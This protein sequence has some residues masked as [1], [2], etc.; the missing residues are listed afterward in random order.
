MSQTMDKASLD[1]E[2]LQRVLGVFERNYR[3]SSADF[4]RAHMRNEPPAAD[5]SRWHRE[6]WSG[7]YRQWLRRQGSDPEPW[8]PAV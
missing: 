2:G 7:T 4:Y 6:I 3:L 1:P 8:R 5:L